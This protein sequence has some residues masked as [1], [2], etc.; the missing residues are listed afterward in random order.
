[1]G[2][3]VRPWQVKGTGRRG[4]NS[5]HDVPPRS[6]ISLGRRLD[7]PTLSTDEVQSR[8]A[9]PPTRHQ[10]VGLRPDESRPFED[11]STVAVQLDG[12]FDRRTSGTTDGEVILQCLDELDRRA[13]FEAM[14]AAGDDRDT[15][16]SP[17]D[18]LSRKL[19]ERHAPG[20]AEAWEQIDARSR[21][22]E[23]LLHGSDNGELGRYGSRFDSLLGKLDPHTN[24]ALRAGLTAVTA[25]MSSMARQPEPFQEPIFDRS[26]DGAREPIEAVVP[27]QNRL[28]ALPP[29]LLRTTGR[30][31]DGLRPPSDELA[32]PE[33]LN[34]ITSRL[35][36]LARDLDWRK[37]RAT[38]AEI[39]TVRNCLDALNRQ[40]DIRAARA[41][42]D[43]H[44]SLRSQFARTYRFSQLPV[45]D[46]TL[47]AVEQRVAASAARRQREAPRADITAPKTFEN[48]LPVESDQSHGR[49]FDRSLD[50]PRTRIEPDSSER[51]P[52]SDLAAHDPCD[53]WIE[54]QP[55][56]CEELQSSTDHVTPSTGDPLASPGE[57]EIPAELPPALMRA[58]STRSRWSPWAKAG[59]AA[60]LVAGIATAG[61]A[62]VMRQ[63]GSVTSMPAPVVALLR[64]SANTVID[65][66]LGLLVSTKTPQRATTQEASLPL[67]DLYGVYAVSNGQLIE[68]ETLPGQVPDPRVAMSASIFRPS[69][70][71]LP[72]GH[73]AFIVFRRDIA[74]NISERVPIRV[75]ARVKRAM[76]FGPAGKPRSA[77][78]ED[79][80]TIRNI[81]F[82]LR[83][84]PIKQNPEMVLLRSE[85]AEFVL[86]PGRYALVLRG[87]AYDFTI[88]GPITEPAQCLE[89]VEAANGS[90]YHE[91]QQTENE[92]AVLPLPYP[93]SAARSMPTT[94]G[95]EATEERTSAYAKAAKLK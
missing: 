41:T 50:G 35:N 29:V 2:T 57:P 68:L 39:A 94:Q 85:N 1:M 74:N 81:S 48:S 47:D 89:R 54:D 15:F 8:T 83:V 40:I 4:H 36:D 78:V 88:A 7:R 60:V 86:P 75:V 32:G 58:T 5:A 49:M 90:F 44:D 56:E 17:F 79:T 38:E 77:E 10:R 23:P 69:R 55:L 53:P 72:S 87:Q 6:R 28:S 25:L 42:E 45:P 67:P 3:A 93:P 95:Q 27:V 43:R 24:Q 22:F 46:T 91:C 84:A 37:T 21:P 76:M 16:H 19:D 71:T 73:I 52:S 59:L 51:D 12:E 65:G 66:A 34:T 62:Y 92:A 9:E 70:I 20:N 64:T 13:S 18:A 63:H 11:P 33:D 26:L 14:L 30:P 31:P 80:W 61:G 82:D